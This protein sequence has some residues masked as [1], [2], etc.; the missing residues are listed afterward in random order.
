MPNKIVDCFI[1]YNEIDLLNYRLKILN[2]VVDYFVIVESTHTFTGKNKSLTFNENKHLFSE[3]QDKIIHI[4]V[5]DIPYKYPNIN[6]SN[7]EQ[8]KNEHFQRNAISRGLSTIKLTNNDLIII[9]DLDEIPDPRT[10]TYIKTKNVPIS[11]NILYMDFYYYNLNTKHRDKWTSAKII[12]FAKYN[13]YNSCCEDI[14]HIY[15]PIIVNG[16]WHL[17][18][19]GDSNFIQNKINN[20]SHQEY[21]ND[22]Y[23]KLEVISDRVNNHIDLFKRGIPIDFIEIKDN[24]YLPID[25]DKYLTAFYKQ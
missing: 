15:A 3:Y 21:N 5:D 23:T 24:N 9:A 22:S 18:Y 17:S 6:V 2:S 16:G 8:W 7:N 19:F 4:I 14:R 13:E 20:F 1:F 11:F 12:S 10:L 25:Y